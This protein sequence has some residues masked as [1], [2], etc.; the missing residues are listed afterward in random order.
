[1]QQIAAAATRVS[2]AAANVETKPPPEAPDEAEPAGVDVVPRG[3][4]SSAAERL[5]DH[6]AERREA[7]EERRELAVLVPAGAPLAL[8]ERVVGRHEH[9]GARQPRVEA[10]HVGLEPGV[11]HPVTERVDDGRVG[12]GRRG[13]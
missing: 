6:H 4:R 8:P 13:A 3:E 10:L 1:M 12:A 5:G 2:T 9:P 11:L 7:R